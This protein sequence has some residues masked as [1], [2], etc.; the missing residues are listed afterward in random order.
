M[1]Q[2]KF[3]PLQFIGFLLISVILMFWFYDNQSNIIENQQDIAVEDVIDQVDENSI[4]LNKSEENPNELNPF[5]SNFNISSGDDM[6]LLNSFYSNNKS[7]KT[8]FNNNLVI[9]T[10]GSGDIQDLIERSL[11]WSGKM[12]MK[13]LLVTKLVG[14]LVVLC[15]LLIFPIITISIYNFQWLFLSLLLFKLLPDLLVLITFA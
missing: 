7:V 3:D 2:N 14:L 9:K 12:K 8:L 11:R 4:N 5:Y 1:E 13:G 6:Y 15:N 10:Q